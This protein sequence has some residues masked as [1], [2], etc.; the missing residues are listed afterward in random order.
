METWPAAPGAYGLLLRLPRARELPLRSL[1]NPR[2]APGAYLYFGSAWGPGGLRARL[3]RHARKTTKHH[4]HIDHLSAHLAD[5]IALPG[6]RECDLLQA[7]LALDG[8]SVPIKRFGATDC[9]RCPAHLVKLDAKPTWEEARA[10]L[11]RVRLAP[12]EGESA[13]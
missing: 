10:A 13:T 3:A 1:N 7:M 5:V 12:S 4:W 8:V 11:G 9:A 2:L 6:A